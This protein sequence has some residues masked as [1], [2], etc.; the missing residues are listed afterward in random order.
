MIF[1]ADKSLWGESDIIMYSSIESR[2]T[3]NLDNQKEILMEKS[4]W[5]DWNK[6]NK[7]F[8]KGLD[9]E[10]WNFRDHT[11]TGNDSWANSKWTDEEIFG[12]SISFIK[13]LGHK[14]KRLIITS[15]KSTANIRNNGYK[16]N[17]CLH[18]SLSF[19]MFA[20]GL[21]LLIIFVFVCGIEFYQKS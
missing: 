12:I 13:I 14:Q 9:V 5:K 11:N 1:S 16:M 17:F 21:S 15:Y 8:F 2:Y 4:T 6:C 20:F 7:I 18:K 3:M 19:L 10:N